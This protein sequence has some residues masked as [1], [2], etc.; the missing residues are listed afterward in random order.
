MHRTHRFRH[1]A[2]ATLISLPL[3]AGAQPSTQASSEPI[4][5]SQLMSQQERDQYRQRMRDA[6][7][8]QERDRIRQ[9]HHDQMKDRAKAQGK[10]LPENPPPYGKGQGWGPG[11]GK[12]H[13][14]GYGKGMGPGGVGTPPGG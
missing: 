3:I 4:Y 8:T 1:L 2:I 10:T 11:H 13:G 14:P 7:T 9:E 5:G 12:G 6:Q